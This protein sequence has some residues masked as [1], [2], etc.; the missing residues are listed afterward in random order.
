VSLRCVQS[1]RVFD[2]DEN[3]EWKLTS[4]WQAHKSVIWRVRK[5]PR[6]REEDLLRCSTQIYTQTPEAVEWEHLA[7]T[8]ASGSAVAGPSH[9]SS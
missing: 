1:I 5:Q 7:A 3:D 8:T 4:Q 9:P 2:K 6:R